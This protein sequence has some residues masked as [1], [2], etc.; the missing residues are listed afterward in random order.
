MDE[1]LRFALKLVSLHYQ[2]QAIHNKDYSDVKTL[3]CLVLPYGAFFIVYIF[4]NR[5]SPF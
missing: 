1:L 4:K 5:R 2:T 3:G